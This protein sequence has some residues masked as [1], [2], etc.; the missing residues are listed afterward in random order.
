MYEAAEDSNGHLPGGIGIFS[1][2][3]DIIEADRQ[4]QH[5]GRDAEHGATI[6]SAN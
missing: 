5:Y 1:V 4:G 3:H 2:Q 6:G